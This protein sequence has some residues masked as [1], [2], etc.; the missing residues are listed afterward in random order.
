L[1]NFHFVFQIY[2]TATT[3]SDPAA[4][5]DALESC[6]IFLILSKFDNHQSD[7]LHRVKDI[8]KSDESGVDQVLSDTYL[9]VLTMFT[10]KEIIPFPFPGQAELQEHPSLK[11]HIKGVSDEPD[12]P[13]F[14]LKTLHSRVIQHN[15]RVVSTYYRR[16]HTNRLAD[17]LGLTPDDL[18]AHLSEIAEGA[19]SASSVAITGNNRF[20]AKAKKP[21]QSEQDVGIYVKIDRPAG[22]INFSRPRA[23]ENILSDWACDVSKMLTLME[24]TCHLIN[25]ENMVH[26]IK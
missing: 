4:L 12:G 21:V 15:L 19:E 3:K 26:K 11:R 14:W 10:T 16:I 13:A 5:R 6:I 17:M 22:V 9:N 25:R 23:P 1:G 8:L 7:M 18:E 20:A 24:S 2:D